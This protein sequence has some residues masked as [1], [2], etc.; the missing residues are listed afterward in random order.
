MRGA[1]AY[2][3]R[4]C[5]PRALA[6]TTCPGVAR[7]APACPRRWTLP[8][9][10]RQQLPRRRAGPVAVGRR[11][12]HRR[13][14]RVRR[15]ARR[16]DGAGRAGVA[17]GRARGRFGPPR[18][19]DDRAVGG[20]PRRGRPRADRRTGGAAGQG[21]RPGRGRP[22][23][24][25]ARRGPA[26]TG[27][28]APSAAVADFAAPPQ[29]AGPRGARGA[30]PMS[31][32]PW[33]ARRRAPAPPTG[34]PRDQPPTGRRPGHPRNGRAGGARSRRHGRRAPTCPSSRGVRTGGASTPPA[35]RTVR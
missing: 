15:R 25:R 13:G 3:E 5:A 6:R 18:R 27:T 35:S 8:V 31:P 28:A 17:A 20:R 19:P 14:G 7:R 33:Q 26:R 23:L 10:A 12:R 9:R 32:V 29:G 34:E 1:R 24:R 16:V 2:G 11:H 4:G 22:P 21:E 30:G